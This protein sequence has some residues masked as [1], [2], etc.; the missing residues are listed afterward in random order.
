MNIMIKLRKLP[1]RV[2]KVQWSILR[3]FGL[4]DPTAHPSNFHAIFAV[5]GVL[6]PK[7]SSPAARFKGL[8]L[9]DRTG[10]PRIGHPSRH[11][12]P[13]QPQGG[14]AAPGPQS[15]ADAEMA[16]VAKRQRARHA[17][18]LRAWA[19]SQWDA[20]AWGAGMR[21]LRGERGSSS[22]YAGIL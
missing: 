12:H 9:G 20:A 15:A 17:G 4:G 11:H 13:R 22:A 8:R 21:G 19:A 2:R 5:N 7:F 14:V 10:Q 3:A 16:Q 1:G 6:G 18:E